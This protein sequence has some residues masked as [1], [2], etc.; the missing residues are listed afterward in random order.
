M[1]RVGDLVRMNVD[2]TIAIVVGVTT[3]AYGWQ[4]LLVQCENEIRNTSSLQVESLKNEDWGHS[5]S[6]V[7]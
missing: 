5:P 6:P 2:S 7:Y 4:R 3:T 1:L